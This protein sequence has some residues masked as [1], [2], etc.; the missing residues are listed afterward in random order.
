YGKKIGAVNSTIEE[1]INNDLKDLSETNPDAEIKLAVMKFSTNCEWMT[2]APISLERYGDWENIEADGLTA[3]GEACEELCSKLSQKTGFM[4]REASPIGYFAPV[5][6]LMSD[7]APTDSFEGS[8][9]K[10]KENKW[11]KSAMK[12]AIA[13]GDD[14]DEEV[15]KKF[16]GNKEL[17]IHADRVNMLKKVI[18][19]VAVTSSQIA[20]SSSSV[21]SGMGMS[22]LAHTDT[23]D[24]SSH[25]AEAQL[26]EKLS[27]LKEE[28][29]NPSSSD[30]DDEEFD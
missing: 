19:T 15:L 24:V 17:V 7:G 28:I 5:I 22:P 27:D 2:P 20:S 25:T 1:L 30:P 3:F 16:T 13:I 11:F 14:A 18:K 26:V 12:I 23:S 8:L 29:D 10:L 21:A 9:A 6:I 4:T